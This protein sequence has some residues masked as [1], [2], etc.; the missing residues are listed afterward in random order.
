MNSSDMKILFKDNIFAKLS[1]KQQPK[2]PINDIQSYFEKHLSKFN[3]ESSMQLAPKQFNNISLSFNN[4]NN[5]I[6]DPIYLEQF[7]NQNEPSKA[8]EGSYYDNNM[9]FNVNNQG[10]DASMS[11]I[12]EGSLV[13]GKDYKQG[14]GVH[15]K[16]SPNMGSSAADLLSKKRK[17]NNKIVFVHSGKIGSEQLV[18][19]IPGEL[20]NSPDHDEV[21]LFYN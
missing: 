21:S 14:A 19:K 17:K 5:Y 7:R 11:N 16:K 15:F 3:K 8:G 12:N 2:I 6:A 18:E 13:G 20:M 10:N 1:E 4:I 9:A